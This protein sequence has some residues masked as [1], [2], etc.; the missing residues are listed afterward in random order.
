MGREDFLGVRHAQ[1][2]YPLEAA[3][4]ADELRSNV[5]SS[6]ATQGA[7]AIAAARMALLDEAGEIDRGPMNV[8]EGWGWFVIQDGSKQVITE[9]APNPRNRPSAASRSS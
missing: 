3:D 8:T 9:Y 1:P 7:A 5:S 4:V 2:Q 6:S